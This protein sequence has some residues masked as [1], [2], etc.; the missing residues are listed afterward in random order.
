M[1]N[2]LR[3]AALER[4]EGP[5]RVDLRRSRL[6]GR[7]PTAFGHLKTLAHAFTKTCDG[8]LRHGQPTFALGSRK[9]RRP[10]QRHTVLV[11]QFYTRANNWTRKLVQMRHQVKLMPGEFVNANEAYA[12][13]A[14]AN[15]YITTFA[16]ADPSAAIRKALAT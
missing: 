7:R 9:S 12:R 5:L 15:G 11:G 16:P 1:I 14:G 4:T 10:L 13:N 2:R 6:A 8:R 3:T